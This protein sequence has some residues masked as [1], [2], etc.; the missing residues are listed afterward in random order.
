QELKA[1]PRLDAAV[2]LATVVTDAQDEVQ[3]SAIAAEL[4]IFLADTIVPRRRVGYL[5]E[6][7]GQIAA[8]PIFSAGPLA[9]GSLPVPAAV[10]TA[11]RTAARDQNLDVRLE[12]LYA[13]G[14]LAAEPHGAARQ[15]VIETSG[16]DIAAMI[17]AQDEAMRVAALRVLGRV[18]ERRP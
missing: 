16:P 12:A 2:P 7:R 8:E 4:N 13:F 17:G 14:A 10:L 18:F 1:H 11:L 3:L 5:V 6:V 9:L 15:D